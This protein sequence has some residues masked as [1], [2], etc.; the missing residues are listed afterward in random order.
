MP[1]A[2]RS[3]H[4]NVEIL[5]TLAPGVFAVND[6][7]AGATVDLGGPLGSQ[8]WDFEVGVGTWTDGISTLTFEHKDTAAASF[9]TIPVEDLDGFQL[10]NVDVLVGSTLVIE[11]ATKDGLVF[12]VAY[13]GGLN[14]VRVSRTTSGTTTGATFYVNVIKSALRFAGKNPM[15]KARWDGAN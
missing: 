4:G 10:N 2:H 6:T 11:D 14:F 7:A 1:A 5:Q 9:V 12:L 8:G 3:I 15:N 13:I